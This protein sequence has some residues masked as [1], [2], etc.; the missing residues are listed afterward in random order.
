MTIEL[1][2]HM[3]ICIYICKLI[4]IYISIYIS[5]SIRLDHI[6]LL[7]TYARAQ[8]RAVSGCLVIVMSLLCTAGP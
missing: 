5:V 7:Y 8:Y 4:Y 3:Y 6:D 2:M 1:H